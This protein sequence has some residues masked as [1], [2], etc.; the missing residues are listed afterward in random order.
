MTVVKKEDLEI[1]KVVIAAHRSY[2]DPATLFVDDDVAPMLVDVLRAARLSSLGL[3]PEEAWACQGAG[4][5]SLVVLSAPRSAREMFRVLSLVERLVRPDGRVLI[6]PVTDSASEEVRPEATEIFCGVYP[7]WARRQVEGNVVELKR[8]VT[9]VSPFRAENLGDKSITR[10]DP[11]RSSHYR[12]LRLEEVVGKQVSDSLLRNKRVVSLSVFGDS[13]FGTEF[14]KQMPVFVTNYVLAHHALFSGWELRI[15]HDEHLFSTNGGDVLCGLERRGL[16]RLVYVPSR[17]GQ[18]KT[19]RMLH[20]LMPAWDVGVEYVV[21]RDVDSLPT[22]RD[23][24]AVEEWVQSGLDVHTVLDSCSHM[25]VMGGLCAFRAERLREAYPSYEAFMVAAGRTDADW[26]VHGMDQL[27]LNEATKTMSVFEH[28]LPAESDPRYG[29]LAA[30]QAAWREGRDVRVTHEIAR[31]SVEG[32]GSDALTN[33]LGSS[34][35]DL[36]RARDFYLAHSPAAEFV[37][38]AEQFA[39]RFV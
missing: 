26:A 15:H 8:V 30:N 16:V 35:Y 28:C 23:R 17:P 39:G 22:W 27:W 13:R 25:G 10:V 29:H 4:S 14:W 34:G 32:V 18:G 2:A 12:P 6:L 24:C 33:H 21:C 7:Q 1:A 11:D 3:A 36:Q 37:R 31:A 19:E 20:R 5:L 9:Y 38:E